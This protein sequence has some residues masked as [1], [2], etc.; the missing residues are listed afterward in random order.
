MTVGRP[1]TEQG[2]GSDR[3]PAQEL[4]WSERLRRAELAAAARRHR[5]RRRV[6]LIRLVRR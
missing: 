6:A 3:W 4:G 5:T 2:T 1:A